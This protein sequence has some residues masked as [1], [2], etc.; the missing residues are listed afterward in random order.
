MGV[1]PFQYRTGEDIR[2]GDRLFWAGQEALM[3]H[4]VSPDDPERMGWHFESGGIVFILVHGHR[5]A[6]PVDEV[7]LDHME[8]VMRSED[9]P[10]K[11]W[12]KG[13]QG[14]QMGGGEDSS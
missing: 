5:F 10:G 1:S 8:F 13:W 4:V 3:E 2:V 12:Q 14:P 6:L 9:D 11:E 7:E